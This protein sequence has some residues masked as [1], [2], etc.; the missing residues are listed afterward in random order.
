[1]PFYKFEKHD[2]FINTIK[3]YPRNEFLIWSGSI[4]YNN[5]SQSGSNVNTPDGHINLYEL[6]VNRNSNLA[7]LPII[8]AGLP[9]EGDRNHLYSNGAVYSRLIR[10]FIVKDTKDEVTM[11]GVGKDEYFND[12]SAGDEI[13]G[14]YPL[15]SSIS[16]HYYDY[17][18]GDGGFTTD[19]LP[20]A[21]DD[22]PLPA[23]NML[24]DG[25]WP[26]HQL[27][28]SEVGLDADGNLDTK[29]NVKSKFYKSGVDGRRRRYIESLKNTCN[30]YT[31]LSPHYEYS[32]SFLNRD[33]SRV[34]LNLISIPSIYYG[35]AIKKGT[36][37]LKFYV[38]G[39]L[40][41]EL[42]DEKANGELIQVGP[43]GIP[44]SGSC[45][46]VVLY[47]EGFVILTGSWDL[48]TSCK[49]YY[50]TGSPNPSWAGGNPD[51]SHW[52]P[53]RKV[54]PRWIYFGSTMP[55]SFTY[56]GGVSLNYCKIPWSDA[57][58]YNHS[59]SFHMAFSGTHHVPT[60][61]MFAHAPKAEL[62]YS[63]NFTFLKNK[64]YTEGTKLSSSAKSHYTEYD[65]VKIKNT[66]KSNFDNYDEPFAKQTFISKIGI[67][68]ENKNLIA[69]AKMANPIR[70]K[71]DRD[72]TFK[73][74]LDM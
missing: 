64:S 24:V 7:E 74:K 39:T 26:Q 57:Q 13:Y 67:Y 35:S 56:R 31:Y 38:T 58:L 21:T 18:D 20:S 28:N 25:K 30:Y 29:F 32:S 52:A 23:E 62:N 41:G 65:K 15:T 33:L 70:K 50:I 59:A 2:Q 5:S 53:D 22:K 37:R 63:N 55:T 46:G 68:D 48:D 40:T 49:D 71:E 60:L 3:A 61:T 72:L 6:N 73:L 10:P 47:N 43:K 54:P 69:V 12:Y 36:V 27:E 16:R 45:A 44:G 9:G 4:Y 11:A 8:G 17:Q 51:Y 14:R 66:V 34:K 42:H 1:M 19:P